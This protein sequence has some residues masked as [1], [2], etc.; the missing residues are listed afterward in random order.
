MKVEIVRG[1]IVKGQHADA[2]ERMNLDGELAKF[3]IEI[4]KAVPFTDTFVDKLKN[5]AIG[6]TKS[7]EQIQ[8]RKRGRPKKN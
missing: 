2:G 6:L 1:C 8:K 4:G 3:L 5:K 7:E